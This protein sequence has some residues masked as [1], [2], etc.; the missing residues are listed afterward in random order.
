MHVCHPDFG[1]A[2][3]IVVASPHTVRQLY[4]VALASH[5]S[6][7]RSTSLRLS[8]GPDG[9]KTP[10]VPPFGSGRPNR[11]ARTTC[12]LTPASLVCA[13]YFLVLFSRT[14]MLIWIGVPT[15]PNSSRRRRSM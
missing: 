1:W 11:V 6:T 12:P 5:H 14:R 7:G 3:Y 9:A 13:C 15:N 8:N 10:I 2:G 4:L